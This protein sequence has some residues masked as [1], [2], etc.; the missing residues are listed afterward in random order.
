MTRTLNSLRLTDWPEIDQRA[1]EALFIKGDV[2]SGAGPA[3]HWSTATRTT[4]SK[5]YARWLGW[6]SRTGGLDPASE[7]ADRATPERVRAYAR[8]LMTTVRPR[9]VATYIIGLK[10]VLAMMAPERDWRW[11]MNL[12]NGLDVWA[13]AARKKTDLPPA[14]EIYAGVLAE[15]ERLS[16]GGF[17]TRR[18]QIAFRDALIVGLLTACPIRLRTLETIEIGGRLRKLGNEWRLFFGGADT[19]NGDPLSFVI[20]ADLAHWLE[21]YILKIRPRFRIAPGC[22]RLWPGCKGAPLATETLYQRV[23]LTTMRLFGV[24]IPPHSFRE[25]AATFLADTSPEDAL[26]APALLGHRQLAT[27]ERHYIRANQVAANR[28]VAEA[29]RSI[30]KR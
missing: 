24:A 6:L 28:K 21:L 12:T 8:A 4:N 5:S 3:R 11:L 17:E 26:R 29:I 10:R 1:W 16:A 30:R 27:T 18:P 7:P 2:L 13:P 22:A 9:T 20:P 25:V 14:S 23:T 15:L 19:K